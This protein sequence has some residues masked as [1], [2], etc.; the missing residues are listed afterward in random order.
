VAL[1][2]IGAALWPNVPMTVRPV[3]VPRWFSVAAPRLG[4]HHVVLPYPAALGGI[5]SSMAWQ[6]TEGMTF[7]MVGGGG[8]G[9]TPSRAGRE[10]PGFNVLARASLP[11]GPAPTPTAASLRAIRRA[12]AGWGVTTVVVPDQP[13]LPTYERGRSVPYAVALFAAALGRAPVFSSRAWVWDDVAHP[14]VAVP[15]TTAAFAACTD[16]GGAHGADAAAACVLH[17]R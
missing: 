12:L 14:G 15:M 17:S 9:I 13:A 11:L 7:S 3:V 1:V 5:Q 4:G 16:I 6:A 2:P 8:P 10:A